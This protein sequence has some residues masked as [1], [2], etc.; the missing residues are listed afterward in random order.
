VA[1]RLLGWLLGLVVLVWIR[2][3][4]LRV[5]D[6]AGGDLRPWVLVFWHGTQVPL[7]AWR[8]RRKTAVLVSWSADGELQARVMARA[9]LR[10]VRGSSSRGGARGLVAMLR[11]VRAGADA[12]FAI[13]GPRGPYGSVHPGA[14]HLA[15][16]SGALLVPMGSAAS[17]ARVLAR[18]W[19]RMRLPWPF[20]RAVVVLG[21][22]LDPHVSEQEIARAIE[23]ANDEAARTL[24]GTCSSVL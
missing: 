7:L 17:P 15:R 2:S 6:H 12:A 3:L 13:D 10:V 16:R 14:A 20:A 9:G 1:L 5:V 19:D 22:P 23:A 21:P 8:R 24:R 18:A 4:R 11:A